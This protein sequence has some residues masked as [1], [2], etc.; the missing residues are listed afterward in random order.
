[1]PA[2]ADARGETDREEET[3]NDRS[4]GTPGSPEEIKAIHRKAYE[5]AVIE[6]DRE[7]V[8]RYIAEGLADDLWQACE[9]YLA[10]FP[11][12]HVVVEEAVVEGDRIAARLVWT[13]THDGDLPGEPATG[14][15]IALDSVDFAR[16]RGG[17]VVEFWNIVDRARLS[18]QLASEPVV[19]TG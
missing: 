18:A 8:G 2:G 19:A 16:V 17:K 3:M 6:R 14:R 9:A 11:D 4:A 1:M 12:L 10:A 13:G 7:A 5:A 15:R